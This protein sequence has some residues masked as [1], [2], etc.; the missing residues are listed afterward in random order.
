MKKMSGF[1]QRGTISQS[2]NTQ[3]QLPLCRNQLTAPNDF[4]LN[5]EQ[6]LL[7]FPVPAFTPRGVSDW[8]KPGFELPSGGRD[9][10]RGMFVTTQITS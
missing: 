7:L 6:L 1:T 2:V 8:M 4:L 5:T 10:L 3:L 9:W